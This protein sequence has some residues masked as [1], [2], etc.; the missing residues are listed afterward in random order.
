MQ[1][2]SLAPASSGVLV[3]NPLA[4]DFPRKST[5]T[6]GS[7]KSFRIC[8]LLKNARL[9]LCSLASGRAAFTHAG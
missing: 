4:P 7:V 3:L 8:P 1:S 2:F 6:V 5:V 9:E